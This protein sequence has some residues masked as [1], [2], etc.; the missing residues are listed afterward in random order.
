MMEGINH[1]NIERD[2]DKFDRLW[3]WLSSAIEKGYIDD[4]K[5][6]SLKRGEAEIELTA[7]VKEGYLQLYLEPAE[8]DPIHKD[9]IDIDPNSES[10]SNTVM[11]S[12]EFRD[13]IE[14]AFNREGW[15]NSG[16]Y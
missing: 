11:D 12:D 5:I 8:G 13:R 4:E 9:V 15:M 1:I 3:K 16:G 7:K 6:P 14:R 10:G 2:R